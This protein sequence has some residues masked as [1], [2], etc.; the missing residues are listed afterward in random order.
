MNR[1]RTTNPAAHVARRLAGFTLIEVLMAAFVL[2]LGVLGLAAMFAGAAR[3]QQLASQ[4]TK[5]VSITQSAD[6]MISD[7]VG[8]LGVMDSCTTSPD[9]VTIYGS[10]RAHAGNWIL[11]PIKLGGQVIGGRQLSMVS[12]NPDENWDQPG[13]LFFRIKPNQQLPRLIYRAAP[14]LTEYYVG[15]TGQGLSFANGG[16]PAFDPL[17]GVPRLLA[18]SVVMRVVTTG[19]GCDASRNVFRVDQPITS[20]VTMTYD[21]DP[22]DVGR[23]DDVAL[24]DGM[25]SFV[26]IDQ[27]HEVDDKV[28]A[29]RPE[30]ESA[31]IMDLFIGGIA[32]GRDDINC[33]GVT[34]YVEAQQGSGAPMWQVLN[35]EYDFIG[36]T[37]SQP[38]QS[39]YRFRGDMVSADLV[40]PYDAEAPGQPIFQSVSGGGQYSLNNPGDG[41]APAIFVRPINADWRYVSEIWLDSFEYRGHEV[42]SAD[43]RVWYTPDP[44][45]E[46]GR[47]ADVAY[48]MLYRDRGGEEG[49]EYVVFT[50]ALR[51]ASS[52]GEYVPPETTQKIAG[53]E[54]PVVLVEDVTLGFDPELLQYYIELPASSDFA[55]LAESGQV[56]LFAGGE[57]L[58]HGADDA[59]RVQFRRPAT[60]AVR[61]YLESPPR[62]GNRALLDVADDVNYGNDFRVW[63]V[64]PSVTSLDGSEWGLR[65]IEARVFGSSGGIN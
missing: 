35:G 46:S 48:S 27:Q 36:N 51:P 29:E 25:G 22:C 23:Q 24:G 59:V 9:Q 53:G 39:L 38:E 47:R 10:V 33:D 16:A 18:D 62:V 42:V 56:L 3:Q 31:R 11:V 61:G 17:F 37:S 21:G 14:A 44:T 15:G 52:Q 55:W 19:Y 54:S 63:A 4:V 60:G 50:Y 13:A 58:F 30:E 49:A 8:K 1:M 26:L 57:D 32:G 40:A 41:S 28:F 43:D 6:S 2:G 20:N 34:D 12:I 64:Q 45:R 65:P 5:S 7:R